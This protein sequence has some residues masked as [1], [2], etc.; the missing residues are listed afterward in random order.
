M[1]RVILIGGN[2]FLGTALTSR[3]RAAGRD[4]VVAS[5]SGTVPVDV[6]EGVPQ[7]LVADADAVVNLASI[8]GRPRI[9]EGT[10]RAVNAEGA[11]RVAEACAAAGVRR[12]V[13]VS[14]TGVLGPTGT[15]P[16]DESAPPRPETPYERTKLE[17]ERAARAF[18]RTVVLRPGHVYGPGDRHML[19]FYRSIAKGTFRTIGGGRALWQPVHVDDVARAIE[20]A[21]DAPGTEGGI[22]H[23]AGS[24]R[25]SLGAFAAR[26]AAALGTTLRGPS[27]PTPLA[28]GLGGLLEAL[29]LPFGSDPPLTRARVRTMTTHRVYA[30][31]RAR[32]SLG[33]APRIG[34]DDGLAG[35]VAWCRAGGWA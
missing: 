19:P 27:I 32:A 25:L 24:E 3:L 9:D 16:L 1:S 4:F 8:L 7:A 11:R 23:V 35:T 21:L 26:I 17:G 20:L 18:A 28:W 30:I 10:Y 29:M 22:F 13:H 2:G 33:W 31:E 5:R 12:L 6:A 34:L 14:T 15:T